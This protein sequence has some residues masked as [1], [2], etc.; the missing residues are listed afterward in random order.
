M[1]PTV[2]LPKERVALLDPAD[3][4]GYLRTHGWVEDR[5]GST[6]QVGRFQYGPD[7]DVTVR[8]PRDRGFLDYAMRVGDVLHTLAVVEHRPSWEVLETLLTRRPE[9]A[10]NGPAAREPKPAGRAPA[11]R[12]KKDAS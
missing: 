4:E 1:S 9:I 5:G 6:A 2:Q 12:A 7:G 10:A 11:P 3:I 8:V